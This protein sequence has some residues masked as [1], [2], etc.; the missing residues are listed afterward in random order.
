MISALAPWIASCNVLAI[1]NLQCLLQRFNLFL[2]SCHT[3]LV[4]DTRVD[5][6][7]LE[8]VEVCK[9]GIQL[10]LGALKILVLC[11]QGLRLILL[12]CSLV[13]N[14]GV[15]FRLVNLGISHELIIL[16]LCS[17]LRCFGV[18]LK[19]GKVRLD[20]LKHANHTAALATHTCVCLVKNLRLCLL[21]HKSCRLR[22]LGIELLQN[23]EGL[24]NSSLSFLRIGDSLCVLCLL[25]LAQFCCFCHGSIEVSD[26]FRQL[27]N[28]L[29]QL[30][31]GCLKLVNLCVQG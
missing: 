26:G 6:R 14:I 29:C 9:S 3:V 17:G 16:F 25:L 22:S 31:N 1:E 11:C 8:L 20:H 5:A 23:S 4:T 2:S 30:R 27:I 7:R 21:L 19:S 28:I 18:R 13:L 10:L 24:R 12:L 15:L